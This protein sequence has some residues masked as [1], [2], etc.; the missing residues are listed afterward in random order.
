MRAEFSWHD[1][2]PAYV[3]HCQEVASPAP[4][5][6][7]RTR[8]KSTPPPQQQKHAKEMMEPRSLE[9]ATDLSGRGVAE[10]LT[11]RGSV[12]D[13]AHCRLQPWLLG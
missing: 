8:H 5:H 2:L 4:G 1:S 12:A 9:S 13:W 10:V 6:T 7:A 3:Q 11:V